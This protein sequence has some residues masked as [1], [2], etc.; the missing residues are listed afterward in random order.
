MSSEYIHQLLH[1]DR[2]DR[3]QA[4]AAADRQARRAGRGRFLSRSS[5]S[6]AVAPERSVRVPRPRPSP[7]STRETASHTVD[8]PSRRAA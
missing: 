3:L 6:A 1:N 5:K 2:A 8:E 4:A 7:E